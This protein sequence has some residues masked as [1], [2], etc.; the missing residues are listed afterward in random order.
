MLLD[1]QH[2]LARI[3][4]NEQ[5]RLWA[6]LC[7][8]SIAN[9]SAGRDEDKEGG[10]YRDYFPQADEY[11]ITNHAPGT[12][13]GH[14]GGPSEILLDLEK[15]LPEALLRR[16][17]IV[18]N[19]TTLEHVFDVRA[20]VAN[21]C[22]MSRDLLLL[23]APCAQVQHDH[24]DFGDYWRFMPSGLR[25]LLHENQFETV[26]EAANNHRN[27]SVYLF[28]AASRHPE[29]WL[30]KAPVTPPLVETAGRLGRSA[31]PVRWLMQLRSRLVRARRDLCFHG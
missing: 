28:F 29:K 6:P 10:H 22:A 3:W 8:G 4:S 12:F 18:L 1:R 5:L 26:Y 17:D 25:R 20:A 16:C 24:T 2:R 31:W 30:G 11:L 27:A 13:R 21:L 19:H 15:P 7:L 14:S 9:V 23:V